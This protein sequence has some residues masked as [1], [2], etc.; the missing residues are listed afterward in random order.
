MKI[1]VKWWCED[2]KAYTPDDIGEH[3]D[4]HYNELLKRYITIRDE[5]E[6]PAGDFSGASDPEWGR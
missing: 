1:T 4:R 5:S 2:C 6:D 3:E